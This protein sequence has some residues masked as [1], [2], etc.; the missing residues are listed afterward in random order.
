MSKIPKKKCK[1]KKKKKKKKKDKMVGK[2]DVRTVGQ[3]KANASDT[4]VKL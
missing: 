2:S 3:V 1:Q 4:G